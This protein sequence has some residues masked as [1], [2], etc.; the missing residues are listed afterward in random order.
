LVLE[1]AELL[2][3]CISG[4]RQAQ[5]AFFAKYAP[6]LFPVCLRYAGNRQ[7]AEDILL[8]GFHKIF[9]YIGKYKGTGSLQGWMRKV[10]VNKAIEIIAQ[11]TKILTIVSLKNAVQVPVLTGEIED[12]VTVKELVSLI[13]KL[14]P[15]YRAVFNLYVFEG[16]KHREIA[17]MLN[18]SVGTSKSNLSD[19][20]RILKEALLTIQSFN[21]SLYKTLSK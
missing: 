9:R 12:N 11:K 20:R 13:Q 15:S 17:E 5:N 10:M 1:E 16:Y 18:I 6:V 14:P 19:A 8:E 2:R 7:E 21:E 3:G 4:N